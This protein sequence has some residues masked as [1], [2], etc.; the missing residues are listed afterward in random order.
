MK[1]HIIKCWPEHFAA[2]THPDPNHRKMAEL[3]LNDRDYQVGDWLVIT[4]Y[5]PEKNREQEI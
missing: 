3:R 4:E 2:L 1:Q 5:D